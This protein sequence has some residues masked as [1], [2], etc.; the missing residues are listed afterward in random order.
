LRIAAV[1]AV[2]LAIPWQ[3]TDPPS[4][5]TARLGNQVLVRVATD[6][7][8][9]GWGEAF[10]LGAPA[11]VCAVVHDALA[12]LV[13][14]ESPHSFYFGPGLAAALHLAASTPGMAWVEW[15]MGELATPLLEVPIRPEAGWLVPPAGPG[16]GGRPNAVALGRHPLGAAP[17]RPFTTTE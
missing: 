17:A 14:G 12:P 16:L 3:P 5:W 7:G 15:P 13:L 1:E 6:E 10:A 4:A 9:V 2:P 8:L 11:A